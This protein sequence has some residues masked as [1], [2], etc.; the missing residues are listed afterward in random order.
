MLVAGCGKKDEPK[1]APTPTPT[2]TPVAHART[3]NELLA[4]GTPTFVAGTLGDDRADRAVRGQIEL[5][6]TLLF[7]SAGVVDDA[8][9]AATGWPDNP[10]VYGGPHVNSAVAAFPLPFEMTANRLA[11]GDEIFEGDATTL[12][13]VVPATGDHPEFLLYAGTGMPGVG[14]IN[15]VSHG[16]DPIVIADE[17]GVLTRGQWEKGVAVLAPRAARIAWRTEERP[18]P[19]GGGES[20]AVV[21][22]RFPAQVAA[23]ADEGAL[24][25]AI[26]RGFS[27]SVTRLGLADPVSSTVYVYPDRRSKKSLTGDQGDGHAVVAAHALHVVAFPPAAIEPLIAH[28]A[29]HVLA[30][31]AWGAAGTSLLGEGLAVWVSGQYGGKRLEEWRP[32]MARAPRFVDLL[33]A[34]FRAQPEHTTYPVAGLLVDAAAAQVGLENVRDHLFGATTATWEQ[35]VVAAGTTSARLQSAIDPQRR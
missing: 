30:Y 33:G 34:G 32:T 28:E 3:P 13:T 14:E 9:I 31:E 16:P 6:R 19:G 1:P 5:I 23:S 29:T 17:F 2:P 10:I 12:I 4:R 27:T 18:L 35:A 15:S 26:M 7:P 21:R 22:L 11:I 8:A 20:G 25:E 24:I